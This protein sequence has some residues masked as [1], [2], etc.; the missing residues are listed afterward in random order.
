M[1]DQSSLDITNILGS[2][3][4]QT[5]LLSGEYSIPCPDCKGD[6]RFIVWP[7]EHP[8]GGNGG[9]FW[10]RGCN[11]SGDCI[12]A[13]VLIHKVTK[14][15]AMIELNIYKGE[16]PNGAKPPPV[17]LT[18]A[19]EDVPQKDTSVSPPPVEPPMTMLEEC[20]RHEHGIEV[21]TEIGCVEISHWGRPAISIPTLLAKTDSDPGISYLKFLDGNK[22]SYMPAANLEEK[23]KE[24]GLDKNHTSC[25]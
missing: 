3:I 1:I 7:N 12:D 11:I 8:K 13:Y 24:R 16:Q 15:M 18:R 6:D 23:L 19:P 21:Y 14:S 22:P 4:G 2:E 20:Q 10:C 9:K 17:D 5:K 25:W